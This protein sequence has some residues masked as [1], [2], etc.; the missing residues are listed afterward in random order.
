[1]LKG[2]AQ[3]SA[4]ASQAR[5]D[6][7]RD[8]PVDRTYSRRPALSP[9]RGG[10]GRPGRVAPVHGIYLADRRAV[11]EEGICGYFMRR[12][13]YKCGPGCRNAHSHGMTVQQLKEKFP[14]STT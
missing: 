4:T 3:A 14:G 7:F 12:G 2:L 11:D 1:M 13:N 6:R 8:R 5:Q 10:F 9:G